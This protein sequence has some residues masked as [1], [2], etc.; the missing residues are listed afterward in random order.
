[1]ARST[2]G[3]TDF[4]TNNVAGTFTEVGQTSAWTEM[5]GPFLMAAG[6]TG[7]GTVHLEISFDGGTTAHIVSRPDGTSTAWT[8]PVLRHVTEVTAETGLL[9]RLRCA[10]FTTAIPYRLSR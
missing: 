1:M 7:E 6:P 5:G 4:T 10:A 3:G 9:Y 8:V 2:T